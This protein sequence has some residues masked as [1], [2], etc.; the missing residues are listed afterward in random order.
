[1][2]FKI[3]FETIV[4]AHKALRVQ[5]VPII[6]RDRQRGHSKMSLTEVARFGVRW[7]RA[8]ARRLLDGPS[9]PAALSTRKLTHD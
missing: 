6:F 4:R 3:A 9:T 5:E 1:V 7:V 2:G 8:I